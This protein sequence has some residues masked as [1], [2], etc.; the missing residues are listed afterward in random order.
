MGRRWILLLTFSLGTLF[1]GERGW[2]GAGGVGSAGAVSTSASQYLLAG[3]SLEKPR[4]DLTRSL[5]RGT[6]V[7]L[8][9]FTASLRRAVRMWGRQV[10]RALAF[11]L[12]ALMVALADRKLLAAWRE[13]GL[14]VLVSY[15]P[16]MLYVYVGLFFDR[17]VNLGAKLFVLGAI[18]YGVIRADLLPD[19]RLVPGLIDDIVLIVL[20][21]RLLLAWCNDQIVY[22][23][24]AGAVNWRRRVL[25]LNRR[26]R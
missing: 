18:A 15:V 2:I 24:A 22:D 21:V 10:K 5:A 26:R 23:H 14:H 3:L 13:K 1:V 6:R 20:A 16:L 4:G 7:A 17:R 9:G 12:L 25:T 8:K 19:R 11:I